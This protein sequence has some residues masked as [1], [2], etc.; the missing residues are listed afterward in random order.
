MVED[1]KI[2]NSKTFNIFRTSHTHTHTE[3]VIPKSRKPSG[4]RQ[5]LPNMSALKNLNCTL[6]VFVAFVVQRSQNG[7]KKWQK[8]NVVNMAYCKYFMYIIKIKYLSTPPLSFS[9][10]Y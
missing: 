7:T 2:V 1:R 4:A 10:C 5:K 3:N 6:H 9:P 8:F